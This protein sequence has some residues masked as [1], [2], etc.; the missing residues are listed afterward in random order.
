MSAGRIAERNFEPEMRLKSPEQLHQLYTL[1]DTPAGASCVV[2]NEATPHTLDVK[3][4]VHESLTQA[5][6]CFA[7]I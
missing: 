3:E 2:N 7:K 4:D 1:A 5:L 6:R